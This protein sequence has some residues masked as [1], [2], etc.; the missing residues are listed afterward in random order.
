MGKV[1]GAANWQDVTLACDDS[2]SLRDPNLFLF[3]DDPSNATRTSTIE[4]MCWLAVSYQQGGT[5]HAI[6]GSGDPGWDKAGR[7]DVDAADYGDWL[8]FS[9]CHTLKIKLP[10][11]VQ[12]WM[13]AN[14]V[15]IQ[16]FVKLWKF[17]P[18]CNA[19]G[20]HGYVLMGTDGGHASPE[21]IIDTFCHEMGHNLGQ[22]YA[23]KA[24]DPT[25]GFDAVNEIPNMP[26]PAGV[27]AGLPYGGL[28]H[29]GTHCAFGISASDRQ[30]AVT[31]GDISPYFSSAKCV[32]YGANDM[33]STNSRPFCDDCLKFI[34]AID[35]SDITKDWT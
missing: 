20:W 16:V 18:E 29:T 5:W 11:D 32:M 6:S 7:N 8:D 14:K 9:D 15:K 2:A 33:T 3:K 34:K 31:N 21:G 13:R 22:A 19:A 27:P 24:V 10:R 23:D 1:G 30:T 35:G 12:D 25:Y 28:G 4:E 26:F 17:W